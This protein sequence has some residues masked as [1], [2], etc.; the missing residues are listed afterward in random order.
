MK[1]RIFLFCLLAALAVSCVKDQQETIQMTTGDQE[2]YATIEEVGEPDTRVYA[3]DQLR[4]RWDA[5][6][7]ISIF[8]KTTY[9]QEYAFQGETGDNSGSFKKVP[10]DDFFT[11]NDLDYIYA[12]YPYQESTRISDDGELTITLPAEQ[13]YRENSFGLGANTMISVSEANELHFKNVGGYLLLKLYGEGVSVSSIT[14][15]G[16]N[17]EKLAGKAT[18]TIPLNGAPNVTMASDATTEITLCCETPVQI[19][20]TADESTQFWFVVPPMTFEKGFT[21]TVKDNMNCSFEKS[22][23]KSFEIGRNKLARMSPLKVELSPSTPDPNDFSSQYLTFEI[24]SDGLISWVS[25]YNGYTI[26][27]T[28]EYSQNGGAWMEITSSTDGTSI[29]VKKGDLLRFRGDN[30]S[31]GVLN[32][33]NSQNRPFYNYFQSSCQFKVYGNIMSLINSTNF[34]DLTTLTESCAFFSLF[35]GCNYLID[36]SHLVLPALT[37][38]ERCYWNMFMDCTNLVSI[39]ELPATTLADYCYSGMF[40]SCKSLQTT[41]NLPATALASHCYERMFYGCSNL[42]TVSDLPAT[43]LSDNCYSTMFYGC[44]SLLHTPSLP[45]I[46]LAEY[47]YYCMFQDCTNLK[48]SVNLPATTLAAY[49]Y[50]Q[51]YM[52]CSSLT[53]APELPAK[54]LVDYCYNN[55]FLGCTSL[56]YIKCLATDISASNCTS[57]WVYNVSSSGVFVKDNSM[58]AWPNGSNGIPK[59]WTVNNNYSEIIEMVDLGLSVKWANM[60]LGASKPEEYGDYFAWGE[61]DSKDDYSW[62]T[63][64][65]SN[66]PSGPFSKYNTDS[67]YGT[68]DNKI[69]LD[70]EDDVAH[71]KL[72]GNWRMPTDAEWTELQ[73]NCTWTWTT[74]NGSKGRLVTASNGNSIFLPAA[75]YRYDTTLAR[76]GSYGY[77]WSSSLATPGAARF[78]RFYSGYVARYSDYRYNGYSIRPVFD[79]RIHPISLTL[80][81]SSLSLPVGR[82][83]QLIATISPAGATDKTVSWS[84]D[85][86]DVATVDSDG[87]V[88][89]VA[90]GSA[91]ITAMTKDGNLTATCSITVYPVPEAVDLGLSV[92]WASFNLGATAPEDYGDYYAWGETEP[93]QKSSYNWPSYKWCNGSSS[94]LTKYNTSSS[95]GTVDN[96]TQLDFEDD[97]ACVNWGGTWRMPTDAEWTELRANCTWTWTIRNGVNGRLVTAS[98][99]NSIFLPVAGCLDGTYRVNMGSYGY[100]WSSSL[101]LDNPSSAWYVYFYS[102]DILRVDYDRSGGQSIRPVCPKE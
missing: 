66:S 15:K 1:N 92:K 38:T 32:V 17:G 76:E 21:V 53:S 55:M 94:S 4:V 46:N 45:A 27:K 8:N 80:N 79:D 86:T 102:G 6:D 77:Y 72:G 100:Y 5:G 7:H 68:V 67:S 48:T 19:G 41:P 62:S 29:S 97:A 61:T 65:F 83:E 60:N 42:V 23:T 51:M 95:I 2:F 74:Q 52:N 24:L 82:S 30:E 98:N 99:G 50:F 37:L 96:K 81:K 47:C 44:S 16:N 73:E 28:I 89:A 22:T 34:K 26:P 59:G 14:L 43:T 12:I 49:C 88:T 85:N 31:Y 58:N 11:G 75:G 101:N 54:V 91:I 63:Y 40:S 57:S 9:N 78:L 39:P 25:E 20:A 71:V 64:E 33:I 93:T 87:F 10:N 70:A 35:K 90:A 3:N 69:V 18:V 56:E 13:S 84:S 36:A